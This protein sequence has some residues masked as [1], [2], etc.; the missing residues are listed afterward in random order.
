M[1]REP[2]DSPTPGALLSCV[3]VFLSVLSGAEDPDASLDRL[4]EGLCGL[5]RVEGSAALLAMTTLTARP[6]LRRRVRLEIAERGHVLPRWLVELDRSR[7][8]V[9]AVEISTVF[10]DIDT[11]VVGVVVPDDHP[12]TAVVRVANEWG[13]VATDGYVIEA[14]VDTVVHLLTQAG[15]PDDQLRDLAPADGRARITEA[16]RLLDRVPVPTDAD[17]LTRS[18]PLIEWISSLLPE[19]GERTVLREWEDEEL[20][21]IAEDFL[22]SPF[23]PSW[24][25]SR[26]PVLDEVLMAG[27][28]NGIGDPLIWSPRNVRSL[29]DPEAGIL[30]SW[31]WDLYLDRVPDLLRDLIR[32]GHG[33][34]GL[35]RKHTAASLHA[36]DIGEGAF[37]TALRDL[38]D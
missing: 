12:L 6:E 10:R 30:R 19:N 33:V 31:H 26:R 3:G 11:L 7:P 9:R 23:G 1:L 21:A 35:R 24:T 20:E 25:S 5:D 22:A 2:L 32:Y 38:E 36:V 14:S 34:R 28:T 29:L 37:R 17:Q 4:L 15:E 18:R 16:F 13:A 27:S 8:V